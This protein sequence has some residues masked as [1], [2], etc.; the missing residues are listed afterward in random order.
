MISVLVFL[1]YLKYFY[2]TIQISIVD[3]FVHYFRFLLIQG[4]A[5]INVGQVFNVTTNTFLLFLSKIVLN[6]NFQIEQLLRSKKLFSETLWEHPKT[7]GYTTFQ[8]P[9][10]ILGPPGGHFG[11]LRFSQKK[12]SNKE[13]YFTKVDRRVK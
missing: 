10:A 13:T 12:W 1:K 8:T 5:A 6:S 11:F 3:F 9:S 4:F 7:W 2:L